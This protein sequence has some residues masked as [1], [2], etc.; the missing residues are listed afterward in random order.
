MEQLLRKLNFS[1]NDLKEYVPEIC[2][3]TDILRLDNNTLA[4]A[5]FS[6]DACFDLTFVSIRMLLKEL[7]MV[8]LR[9]LRRLTAGSER[10]IQ[11]AVPMPIAIAGAIDM[12][13]TNTAVTSSEYLIIYLAGILFD[14]YHHLCEGNAGKCSRCGLNLSRETLYSSAAYPKPYGLLSCF[15]YCDELYKAGENL[16]MQYGLHHIHLSPVI[17]IPYAEQEAYLCGA[18]AHLLRDTTGAEDTRITDVLKIQNDRLRELSMLLNTVD[19]LVANTPDAYVTFNEISLMNSLC[20]IYFEGHY[21]AAKSILALF[22]RELRMR[23]K[24]GTPVMLQPVRIGC[25]HLPFTN[26]SIDRVF[27]KSGA[28]VLVASMYGAGIPVEKE[29]EY[30]R[31]LSAYFGIRSATPEEKASAI[32]RIIDRYQLDAFLFGQFENDRALGGDQFMV[33]KLLKHQDR[34]FYFA[35]DNWRRTTDSD[36]TRIESLVEVIKE[37]KRYRHEDY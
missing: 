13:M 5:S 31:C 25:M 26:P 4:A 21:K 37:R 2:R 20:L 27:C 16:S 18:L 10:V 34:C 32:D 15:A 1:D 12:L 23:K 14:V 30:A 24:H 6:L 3:L 35:I 9:D 29:N 19:A 11:M 17:G 33:M 7:V 28:A 36:I 22:I 8:V